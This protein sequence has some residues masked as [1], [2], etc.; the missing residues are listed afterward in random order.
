MKINPK[1]YAPVLWLLLGLF[2]FRVLAQLIQLG[3]NLPF[4]PAF[5]SWHSGVLPYWLLLFAQGIIILVLARVA[6]AFHRGTV[7][8]NRFWGKTWSVLGCMYLGVMLFRF[9]LGITLFSDDRW[10]SNYMATFFH[11][12]LVS[13]ILLIGHFNYKAS[14]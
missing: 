2:C 14:R 12:V 5:E 13:F 10:Y 6:L 7:T 11:I 3:L 9:I 1:K 4:L 8:P